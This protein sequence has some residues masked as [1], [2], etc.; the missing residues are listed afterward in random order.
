MML[1]SN[2]IKKSLT[3]LN[4]TPDIIT[5]LQFLAVRPY[6]GSSRSYFNPTPFGSISFKIFYF[7]KSIKQFWT[8]LILA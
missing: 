2:D 6:L 5:K 3:I 1:M 4:S 7:R 8:G